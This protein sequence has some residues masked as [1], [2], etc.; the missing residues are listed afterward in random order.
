MVQGAERFPYGLNAAPHGANVRA[1]PWSLPWSPA[2][3]TL[4]SVFL[5]ITG[6]R[7]RT[8]GPDGPQVLGV[9]AEDLLRHL[10]VLGIRL[11]NGLP[12]VDQ[13]LNCL[14]A[15]GGFTPLLPLVL[16]HWPQ[17]VPGAFS[18]FQGEKRSGLA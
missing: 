7:T 10:L 5:M 13:G 12:L 16:N 1:N 3:G 11:G 6:C 15:A 4:A 14:M 17:S 9:V 2:D 18:P 8:H